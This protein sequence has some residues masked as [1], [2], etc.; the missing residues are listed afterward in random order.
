M[1]RAAA[2][3]RRG[4]HLNQEVLSPPPSGSGT[5]VNVWCAPP[6]RQRAPFVASSCPTWGHDFTGSLCRL[7]LESF[8]STRDRVSHFGRF[9]GFALFFLGGRATER[10]AT[11]TS[12]ED[13]ARHSPSSVTTSHITRTRQQRYP[14]RDFLTPCS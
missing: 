8:S 6:G 1:P 11:L 9:F 7:N 13:E 2:M 14:V 3:A 10:A 4:R 12:E 5:L